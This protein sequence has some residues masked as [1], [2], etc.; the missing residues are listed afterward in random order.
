MRR[1]CAC[2]IVGTFTGSVFFFVI[3]AVDYRPLKLNPCKLSSP[4]PM[5]MH[6]LKKDHVR[7]YNA[8]S[9]HC[10]ALLL[11]IA[12]AVSSNHVCVCVCVFC[13]CIHEQG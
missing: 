9:F 6:V 10:G 2:C 8:G 7:Q 5:E 4:T 12:I 1:N 3:F 13:V 11:L